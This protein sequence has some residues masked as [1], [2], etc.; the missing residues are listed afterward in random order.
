MS[1]QRRT[2][3]NQRMSTTTFDTVQ[4]DR[5]APPSRLLMLA[6]G[7]AFWETGATLMMWPWLQLAPRG[8]GHPVLV[9]PGLVVSDI[10]TRL[11]R[12][13]LRGRGHDVHGWGLGNNF[14]PRPGVE[15]AMVAR[16]QA[17]HDKEGRKVSLVGWSLGG[18]F[19]RLLAS[20]HPHLVRDVVTLGSPFAGSPRATNAAWWPGSAAST[21][22]ARR[23]RTSR[24]SPATWAWA[25]TRPF[26]THWPTAWP[27]LKTTGSP[28]TA[29]VSARWCTRTRH[30]N[31]RL[32]ASRASM[33]KGAL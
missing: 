7:R 24:C 31:E 32:G 15:A 19:A 1:G 4:Q 14:G 11:L 10:S 25:R 2:K 22:P 3:E 8:D 17:L 21:A 16:L 33:K 23:T 27:S 29:A 30:A 5:I 20:R 12:R 6:E 26:C 9:L 18:V 28:S 13:Y